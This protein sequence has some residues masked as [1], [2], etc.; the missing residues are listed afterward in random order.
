MSKSLLVI[1]TPNTCGDCPLCIYSAEE[2]NIL[3]IA[4]HPMR[5]IIARR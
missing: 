5:I 1:D 4:I 3:V 2:K